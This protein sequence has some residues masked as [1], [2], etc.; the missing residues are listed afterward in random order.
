VSA[1]SS[2]A[3]ALLSSSVSPPLFTSPSLSPFPSPSPSLSPSP[4]PPPPSSII[5]DVD[6]HAYGK[7]ANQMDACIH[8]RA[9]MQMEV[10]YDTP[11]G[12]QVCLE[13]NAATFINAVY[14]VVT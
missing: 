1:A 6:L 9:G 4:S 14:D 8:L 12:K 5:P 11:D 3:A 13:L 2:Q 7:P 10:T